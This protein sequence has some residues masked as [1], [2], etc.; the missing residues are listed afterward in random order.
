L[1]D[2]RA[3]S[4]VN[5]TGHPVRIVS[6]DHTVI[7]IPPSGQVARCVRYPDRPAGTVAVGPVTVPIVISPISTVVVGLPDHRPGVLLVVSRT[8]ATAQPH[9]RDLVFPHD[10]LRDENGHP[11]GCRA[12]GQIPPPAAK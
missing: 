3:S 6:P 10:I 4:V 8:V 7:D 2:Q 11:F 5:L 12:F 9:R 1:S